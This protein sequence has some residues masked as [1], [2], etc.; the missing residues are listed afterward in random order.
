MIRIIRQ[1]NYDNL[2]LGQNGYD[3][4]SSTHQ[5]LVRQEVQVSHR[6]IQKNH[7]SEK[8]NR[9]MKNHYQNINQRQIQINSIKKP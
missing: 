6:Q 4:D 5:P 7:Y 2:H 9:S 3:L 1:E 8:Q